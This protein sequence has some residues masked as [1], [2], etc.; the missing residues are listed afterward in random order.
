M[1]ISY[2][3]DIGTGSYFSFIK[4]IF[5]WKGSLWKSIWKELILWTFLYYVMMVLYKFVFSAS[6]QANF[7]KFASFIEGRLGYFQL[8]F[9]LGF[10]VTTVVD[11]WKTVFNNIGFIDE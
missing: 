2:N 9:I 10:F 11:R 6:Y 1:T 7:A 4:I 8:T 3:A 5:R